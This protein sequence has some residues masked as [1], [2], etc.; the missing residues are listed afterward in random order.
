LKLIT[1]RNG[2]ITGRMMSIPVT[3]LK[4]RAGIK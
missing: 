3:D 1:S 2:K 4:K